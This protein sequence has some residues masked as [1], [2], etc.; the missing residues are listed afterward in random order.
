MP[1]MERSRNNHD[2]LATDGSPRVYLPL[3]GSLRR[4]SSRDPPLSIVERI[5]L[6]RDCTF[7]VLNAWLQ[8]VAR[9]TSLHG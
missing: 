4:R 6:C 5:K 3:Q 8:H 9:S 7:D 2:A 1:T